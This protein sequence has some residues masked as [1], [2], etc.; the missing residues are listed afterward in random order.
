M[1]FKNSNFSR[2]KCFFEKKY[3][4]Q[5]AFYT[6]STVVFGQAYTCLSGQNGQNLRIFSEIWFEVSLSGQNGIF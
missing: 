6:L 2:Q 1:Q 3:R 5:K 4:R